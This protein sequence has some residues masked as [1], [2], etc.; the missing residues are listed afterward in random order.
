M[1]LPVLL[2][3]ERLLSHLNELAFIAGVLHGIIPF[4]IPVSTSYS[5]NF[6]LKSIY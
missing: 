5:L 1:N 6:I 3:A 2:R 4:R